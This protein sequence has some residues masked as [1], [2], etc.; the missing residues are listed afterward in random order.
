MGRGCRCVVVALA[1]AR[2]VAR[3][4]WRVAVA[5]AGAPRSFDLLV[6]H[7]QALLDGLETTIPATVTAFISFHGDYNATL[8]GLARTLRQAAVV[9]FYAGYRESIGFRR[10][11][12]DPNCLSDLAEVGARRPAISTR[13]RRWR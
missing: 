6:D 8:A 4:P 10:R 2:V 9:E 5:S 1:L 7:H 12:W 13:E 11:A 3:P